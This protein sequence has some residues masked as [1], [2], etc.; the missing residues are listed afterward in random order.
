MRIAN[1]AELALQPGA[2]CAMILYRID[3]SYDCNV[4][5][6]DLEYANAKVISL[7][8]KVVCISE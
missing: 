3:K 5:F 2:F 7:L 8:W 4:L 6:K 1:I